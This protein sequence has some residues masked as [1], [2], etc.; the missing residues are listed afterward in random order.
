[1]SR[2]TAKMEDELDHIEDGKMKWEKVVKD[3]YKPFHR[4]LHEAN[5]TVGKVKPQDIPTEI[6]CEKCGLPMV[7]RWGRHGRF[8]ACTGFPNCKNT[9]PIRQKAAAAKAERLRDRLTA[10]RRA[11]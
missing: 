9:K 4:D 7:I 1:M 8:I 2:F 10:D 11:M 5:K 6:V 3:F